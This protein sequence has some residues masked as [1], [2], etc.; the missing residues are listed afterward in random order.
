[1]Q[2]PGSI[3]QVWRGFQGI[4]METFTKGWWYR[5]CGGM[6]RQRT[7]AE[8][9]EHRRLY[10]TGG[11]CFDLAV[12]LREALQTAGVAARITGHDLG[13]DDAHV[14]VIATDP[15]GR[16]Y[17]CDLG[18]LWLQPML[19]DRSTEGFHAGFFPGREIRLER[20]GNSLLVLYR[21]PAIGKVS[22]Q[23]FDLSPV[24]EAQFEA[25]CHHSQSLLRRPFCE[26][27]L[28]HPDTGAI[29]H[30]EYDRG[31]SFWN[32]DG[33]PVFEDACLDEAHWVARISQ[34]TG[35]S[36]GI[37]RGAFEVYGIKPGGAA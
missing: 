5:Q 10:G 28:S 23:L 13:T 22:R 9:T 2:A 14:A 15:E 29:T 30:W 31:R 25:A 36:A 1:M 16:E 26:A 21:R 19:I 12:W 35:M 8:M 32:M 33:G 17:L 20:S 7:V 6:P 4:P 37:V 34:R 18:D 27:L 24:P 11:N 3:L